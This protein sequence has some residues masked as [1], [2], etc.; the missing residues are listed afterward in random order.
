[1]DTTGFRTHLRA[2][3]EPKRTW[4]GHA[5]EGLGAEGGEGEDA[6]GVSRAYIMELDACLAEVYRQ[7]HLVTQRHAKMCQSLEDFHLA[8]TSLSEVEEE[9]SQ[10]HNMFR[11]MSEVA[12][13]QA[14]E[15]RKHVD[16]LQEVFLLI[17][18]LFLSSKRSSCL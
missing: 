3:S 15:Y 1:M 5:K 14:A 17:K 10:M 6:S 16:K 7:A 2:D 18:C 11:D 12:E 4:L 9:G 8:M 13:E